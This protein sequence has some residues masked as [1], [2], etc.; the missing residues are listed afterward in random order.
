METHDTQ[1]FQKFNTEMLFMPKLSGFIW[2]ECILSE[3]SD[4]LSWFLH[5]TLQAHTYCVLCKV[6]LDFFRLKCDPVSFLPGTQGL[7]GDDDFEAH[8][9][10]LKWF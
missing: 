1:L 5:S 8:C 9:A 3:L 4:Q 6:Q 2:Q 10:F 7:F